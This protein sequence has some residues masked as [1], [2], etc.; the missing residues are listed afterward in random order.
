MSSSDGSSMTPFTSDN[1]SS[2]VQSEVD[3][4]T[5]VEPS[6]D[7]ERNISIEAPPPAPPPDDAGR[8]DVEDNIDERSIEAPPPDEGDHTDVQDNVDTRNT[9]SNV[10]ATPHAVPPNEVLADTDVEDDDDDAAAKPV[11]PP[12]KRAR[13]NQ[14]KSSLHKPK[15][16]RSLHE[17]SANSTPKAR[18]SKASATKSRATAVAPASAARPSKTI[19]KKSAST[20][21]R[22]LS[23]VLKEKKVKDKMAPKKPCSAFLCFSNHLRKQAEYQAIVD[24]GDRAKR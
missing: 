22:S 6:A 5:D 23:T 8:T 1:S 12:K 24:F 7:N 3:A 11:P 13:F 16:G 9:E 18:L 10:E 2:L 14:T 17:Q 20:T 4:N 21:K 15:A 19:K